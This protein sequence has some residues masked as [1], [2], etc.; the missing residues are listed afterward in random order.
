MSQVISK[1]KQIDRVYW[2]CWIVYSC[3]YFGRYNFSA[4]IADIVSQGLYTKTQ[5]GI[6][7]TVF[8][9]V[10]GS[11]QLIN[12]ILGDRFSPYKMIFFGTFVSSLANLS[13]CFASNLAWL[14]VIW[15]VNGFAQSMLW[16]P[17]IYI[18]SNTI[19]GESLKKAEAWL[20]ATIPAGTLTAYAITT[21]VIRVGSWR[22]VFMIASAALMIVS[23]IWGGNALLLGEE[24]R[25]IVPLHRRNGQDAPKKTFFAVAAASGFLL[26]VPPVMLHAMLKDG[27]MTWVPTM[28]M[29]LFRVTPSFSTLLTIVLPVLNFFGAVVVTLIYNRG[30][31]SE[32]RIACL[33]FTFSLLPLTA[34]LFIRHYS[35][36]VSVVFLALIT[37]TM[38]GINHVFLT[39]I[40]VCFAK[41]GRAATMA[42]VIDCVAYAGSA[43][44]TYGFGK[45][46]ESFGWTR[47]IVFWLAFAAVGLAF[48][49]LLIKKWEQYRKGFND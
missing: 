34:L 3:S 45:I 25:R 44:S 20:A 23:L 28:I 49:L 24:N 33:L 22:S 17:I 10:Y 21:L 36:L 6:V 1:S 32:A 46:A 38:C 35:P 26:M 15:G 41:E 47:I 48:C 29:E 37:S 31:T 2:L 7:G 27:V 4:A 9:V 43:L 30:K 18:V 19:Q 16:A 42:G 39:L 13:M 11:G 5:L 40:P 12:G 14:C 8:F